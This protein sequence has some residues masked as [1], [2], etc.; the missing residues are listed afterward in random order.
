[1]KLLLLKLTTKAQRLKED[2][3]K[4]ILLSS[5]VPLCLGGNSSREAQK[6][7]AQKNTDFPPVPCESGLVKPFKKGGD[8]LTDREGSL[9]SPASRFPIK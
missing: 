2:K 7:E 4:G 9:V 1:M 8:R 5:L 3:K 6:T